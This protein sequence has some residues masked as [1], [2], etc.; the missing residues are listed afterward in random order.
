MNIRISASVI[1][2][3]MVVLLLLF[4]AEAKIQH[5]IKNEEQAGALVYPEGYRFRGDAIFVHDPSMAMEKGRYYLFSTDSHLSH[6]YLQIRRSDDL[7]H[8]S[9]C[10]SIF[11]KLP[12]WIIEEFPDVKKLWA[13]DISYFQGK[14]HVYYAVSRFGTNTSVI[15]LATNVTLDPNS[16]Q[17]KWVDEGPVLHSGT[18]DYYNAIDP[19]ILINTDGSVWMSFGSFFAGIK[20]KRIDPETG[21]LDPGDRKTYDLA[22]RGSI[23]GNAIEAPFMIYHNGYYY[24]FVSFDF[25][26]R[27]AQSTYRTM[28][29]RSK[30]LYGPFLDMEGKSMMDGGGTELMAGNARWAGPGG[31]SLFKNSKN[32]WYIVFHAYA[33]TNGAPWLQALPVHWKNNWP[34]VDWQSSDK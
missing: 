25:C 10:G 32:G 20:M 14:Y 23:S 30:S 21:K 2:M 28:F 8:W 22:S 4:A 5:Q 33:R 15:G 24:L 27:G 31:A 26:C 3:H 29:G 9:A 6:G 7:V 1:F 19:S 12:A 18:G 34:I 17:Y 13:P 11:D 16:P